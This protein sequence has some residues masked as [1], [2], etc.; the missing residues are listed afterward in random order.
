MSFVFKHD[1][2][3]I[4]SVVKLEVYKLTATHELVITFNYEIARQVHTEHL[5][6]FFFVFIRLFIYL[7]THAR[8]FIYLFHYCSC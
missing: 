2:R 7:F 1:E 4:V 8:L 5:L 6:A 3:V